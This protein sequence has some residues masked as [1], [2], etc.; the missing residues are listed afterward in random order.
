MRIRLM[1]ATIVC[2]ALLSNF[3]L[4]ATPQV[5]G[6]SPNTAA[7]EEA[8]GG[9]DPVR[10]V[11]GQEV[12]GKESLAVTYHGL[13]YYFSTPETKAAFEADPSR[14][15]VQLD[16]L[17]ARMGPPVLGAQSLYAVH[18]GRI[19]VFGA[20]ECQKL[21]KA[22]AARYLDT[23][24]S[25]LAGATPARLAAGRAALDRAVAAH[26][27]AALA[28]LHGFRERT[29]QEL[30]GMQGP[31]TVSTETTALLPDRW[32][33]DSTNRYGRFLLVVTPES[34]FRASTRM[35]PRPI[36]DALRAYYRGVFG[37]H[38]LALLRAHR[39]TPLRAASLDAPADGG[40]RLD[41]VAV[42]HEGA[43][44]VLALDAAGRIVS[45]TARAHGPRD[46]AMA[47]IVRT[48]SDFRT[49]GAFTL[50]YRM[51]ATVDG[52]ANADL[53]YAVES[54]EIDPPF[55]TA[56]LVKPIESKP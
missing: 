15:G 54:I 34:S 6:P 20:E 27:G 14:Y 2:T 11:Q 16:G 56:A 46:G 37:A 19:Y 40:A 41:R 28:S 55:D 9:L 48:W 45:Q 10:L 8:L 35:T 21:F 36:P 5:A 39:V 23:T 12:D 51:D 30:T 49:V 18:D 31:V 43:T 29:K 32:R 7:A 22:D 42:E 26:G 17:C 44:V 24:P 3:P 13:A 50:P 38:P 1:L 33:Q 52:A 25:P 53:S 47:T 4:N